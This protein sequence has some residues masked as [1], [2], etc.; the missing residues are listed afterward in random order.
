[1][2]LVEKNIVFAKEIINNQIDEIF[3]SIYPFTTE[4]IKG[5]YNLLDFKNKDVLT[6]GSSGD[7]TL[8]LYLENIKSVDY[9]DINPFSKYYYDLK[10]TAIQKL[11]LDEF[12]EFFCYS[13][14]PTF[15]KE[16][17]KAFSLNT[18]YRI[19]PYLDD[20]TKYFWDSLYLEY[21]G[22]EI[23]KS[24]LFS[25]DEERS[26]ILCKSN[27][28]LNYKNYYLLKETLS[29]KKEPTFY[30]SDI[31]DI[32]LVKKYDI[33][34][35][36]NIA[37]YLEYMYEDNYLDNF[38][39]LISRLENNL[40]DNGIIIL[41]YLYNINHSMYSIKVPSIYN[42]EELNKYFDY[43]ILKFRGIENIKYHQ[44][45]PIKDAIIVYKKTK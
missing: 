42:L 37:K 5:Y 18:Y 33:I 38:Y 27:N 30:N 19:L 31:R 1:M 25:K 4:N 17:K 35:L 32:E 36:S 39:K 21:T 10:K 40:N 43:D 8:N 44:Q 15:L 9:F 28:Y 45:T 2:N 22:L 7:H 6:V 34:M 26:S 24:N 12:L 29:N 13:N 16:N 23:R 20:K 3:S 41:S 14:F 11:E